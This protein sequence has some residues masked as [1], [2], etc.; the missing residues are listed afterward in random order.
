MPTLHTHDITNIGDEE[1]V[2][3]FWA[4]EIF[5]PDRPDTIFEP[6]R[7]PVNRPQGDDHPRHPA[8]DHPPV[9]RDRARSTS[10]CDHVL[11]HTGQNYDYELNEV[12]FEDLGVRAPDHYPRRRHGHA[13]AAS[14]ATS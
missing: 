1:L 12:F 3:L 5:D 6:V 14:S 7:S 9:A 8:G 2:T 11:V 4:H 13:S 10:H